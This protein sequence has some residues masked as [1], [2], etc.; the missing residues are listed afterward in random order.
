MH[1]ANM[2]YALGDIA[3]LGLQ[4]FIGHLTSEQY[5]AV[6][7]DHDDALVNQRRAG[8]LDIDANLG[9]DGLILDGRTPGA[10]TVVQVHRLV[11]KGRNQCCAPGQGKA[12]YQQQR[13]PHHSPPNSCWS[14]WSHSAWMTSKWT[15]WMRAVDCAG[16]RTS[17]SPGA[18]RLAILPPSRPVSETTFMPR[19]W[20]AWMA[21]TTL[22][23]L[24]L[25]EI[26][27][28]TS[29]WLPSARICLEKISL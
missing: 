15:S 4:F 1:M 23:E 22:A 24:P 27:S 9:L 12:G 29:P 17:T 14:M 28:R 6:I 20:A 25:V 13:T 19:S 21:C 8:A 3:G 7:A 16:T 11:G 26:A 5:I 2:T 10:L 18:A